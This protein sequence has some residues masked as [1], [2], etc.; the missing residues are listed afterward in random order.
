MNHIFSKSVVQKEA[1]VIVP[2]APKDQVVTMN[3]LVLNDPLVLE[4]PIAREDS[5]VREEPI[6]QN[7]PVVVKNQGVYLM[8]IDACKPIATLVNE[9]SI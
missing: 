2:T 3:P 6:V 5:S 9:K 8:D 7:E 1:V 4:E